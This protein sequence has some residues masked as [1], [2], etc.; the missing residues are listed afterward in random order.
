M[1][2]LS[3]K[4]MFKC[5]LVAFGCCLD[6]RLLLKHVVTAV[7][8]CTLYAAES[9]SQNNVE[10]P[11]G[12]NTLFGCCQHLTAGGSYCGP[13]PLNHQHPGPHGHPRPEFGCQPWTEDG[14]LSAWAFLLL[15]FSLKIVNHPRQECHQGGSANL[16]C[17]P[18]RETGPYSLSYRYVL[19][20]QTYI[21]SRIACS[22]HHE[23]L[24]GCC[25][26]L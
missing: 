14:E 24:G 16:C 17:A 22:L 3:T 19:T 7:L 10:A 11:G 9:P 2:H 23:C 25:P 6:V 15:C 8:H 26:Y 12:D 18:A 4:S 1:A 5:S 13:G 20:C 21:L